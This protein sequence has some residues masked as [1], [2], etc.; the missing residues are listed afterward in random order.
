M[1]VL[2]FHIMIRPMEECVP[3]LVPWAR[4]ESILPCLR[5]SR[6]MGRLQHAICHRVA[7]PDNCTAPTSRQL[8]NDPALSIRCDGGLLIRK[9]ASPRFF[10]LSWCEWSKLEFNYL[11]PACTPAEHTGCSS[12]RHAGL[13]TRSKPT[14]VFTSFLQSRISPRPTTCLTS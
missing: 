10:V 7:T 11:F 9:I 3:L 12:I 2:V 5:I 8:V 14:F 1:S 13:N 6:K 4:L